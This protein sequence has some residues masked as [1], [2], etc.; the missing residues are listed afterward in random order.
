M[1][2]ETRSAHALMRLR[3]YHCGL[4]PGLEISYPCLLLSL[5]TVLFPAN[6]HSDDTCAC[7]VASLPVFNF[8]FFFYTCYFFFCIFGE[9]AWE[10]YG[11]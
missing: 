1:I 10:I 11:T 7:C 6:M 4:V 5:M 9:R 3:R 8:F 2:V